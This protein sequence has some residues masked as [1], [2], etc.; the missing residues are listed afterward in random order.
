MPNGVNITDRTSFSF[1]AF[2]TYNCSSTD[3]YYLTVIFN[4]TESA[5][6]SYPMYFS[7]FKTFIIECHYIP[8]NAG[9]NWTFSIVDNTFSYP[10]I[11][12]ETVTVTL[13]PLSLTTSTNITIDIDDHFTSAD[14]FIPNCLDITDPKYL[15]FRCNSSDL[16]NNTLSDNCTYICSNLELGSIYHASLIRLPIPIVDE[17]NNT[18]EL[19]SIHTI[20]MTS[21]DIDCR[22]YC[23]RYLF[24][25][26][27]DKVTN[28]TF[29]KNSTLISFHRPC[30]N[31]DEIEL[32]CIASYQYCSSGS[33]YLVNRT[34]NCPSCNFIQ[35]SPIIRGVEY[36]CQ[37]TTIKEFFTY[38][39]SDQLNFNTCK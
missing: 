15:I 1:T 24:I 9:R 31:Y 12:N 34:G 27:L 39:S 11:L 14:I 8:N 26:D 16:S 18:F 33:T 23:L 32:I 37:A 21:K 2:I 28:L 7:N 13:I 36:W 10:V 25:L 22:C 17:N 38:V 6:Y 3:R 5:C 4:E 30:G 20:Y 19:E 29:N 35:I